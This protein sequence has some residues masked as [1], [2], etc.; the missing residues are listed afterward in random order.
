VALKPLRWL[1]NAHAAIRTLPPNARRDAG[2]QLYRVQAGHDP[3]DWKPMAQVGSG[4]CEIRIHVDGEFRV[5]YLATRLDAVYVLHAFAKKSRRT[6]KLDVDLARA[7][8]KELL[9]ER[10]RE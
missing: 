3:S 8:L 10:S 2:Y 6:R 5:L 9:R 7:R 4:V 1:G